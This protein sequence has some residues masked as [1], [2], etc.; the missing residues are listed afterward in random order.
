MK[1]LFLTAITQPPE[2]LVYTFVCFVS[3]S[4]FMFPCSKGHSVRAYLDTI[5]MTLVCPLWT[6]PGQILVWKCSFI[7]VALESLIVFFISNNPRINYFTNWI[8]KCHFRIRYLY[9]Y[10]M[11]NL[12]WIS[13]ILIYR[14]SQS[15]RKIVKTGFYRN[16]TQPIITIL[17]LT[18]CW[19]WIWI[20]GQKPGPCNN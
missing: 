8:R 12:W 15:Y 7:K 3:V 5:W 20:K 10:F 11:Y 19:G 14:R 16:L 18:V 13:Q 6:Y 1:E 17:C 4:F 9:R 2:V